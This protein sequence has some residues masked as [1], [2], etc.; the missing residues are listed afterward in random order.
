M[1][2]PLVGKLCRAETLTVQLAHLLH[3]D[4][5]PLVLS[6][7]FNFLFELQRSDIKQY[8]SQPGQMNYPSAL[9]LH[10]DELFVV[11][12]GNH[13]I[14]V[15]HQA[16]G[17]FLRSWGQYTGE[18]RMGFPRAAAISL[19]SQSMEEQHPKEWEILEDL[20]HPREWEI[21]IANDD[22]ETNVFRISDCKFLRRFAL[23]ERTLGD[24]PKSGGIAIYED[25]VYVSRTKPSQIDVRR[26]ANGERV[27][28]IG[29][30]RKPNPKNGIDLS[31]NLGKIFIDE[32]AKELFLADSSHNR[33]LAFDV[34]SGRLHK[35]YR[36]AE[37][38]KYPMER[39]RFPQAV[40]AHGDQVIVCDT[41][42]HRL[43]VFERL[44]GEFVR[45]IGGVVVKE[46]E[47]CPSNPFSYP[48][49]MAI[50]N[51]NELYVCNPDNRRVLV[52]Q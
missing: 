39:L 46:T 7:Q 1:S 4:V 11:D 28:T 49:D 15:F 52:F 14:Q 23:E 45:T 48:S 19:S 16:T 26:K 25:Y 37:G 43:V 36:L 40:V 35:Q 34:L 51:L 47:I 38:Q 18:G 42:N 8:G 41:W 12:S 9:V 24:H 3:P 21:F 13:R 27:R 6:Y 33:V 2:G 30:G 29:T 10:E 22:T 20:Q 17:R 5:I 44:T 50:S 32:A 31:R